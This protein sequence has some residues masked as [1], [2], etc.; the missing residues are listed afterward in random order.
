M[1]VCRCNRVRT[2]VPLAGTSGRAYAFAPLPIRTK[3]GNP[4][5][6][7]VTLTD[8]KNEPRGCRGSENVSVRITA[9]KYGFKKDP[10]RLTLK[11]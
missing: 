10:I 5:V 7:G 6:F 2:F 8:K 9:P 11:T 1:N 4:Y 3:K